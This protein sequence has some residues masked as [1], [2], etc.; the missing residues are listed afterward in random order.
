M[1]RRPLP[2]LLVCVLGCCWAASASVYNL[3][4]VTDASPDY[5]DMGSTIRS[6]TGRWETPE[7][8]C[9]AMFYWTH[10]ARRQCSPMVLHGLACSDPIRQFNDYGYTMCSTIAGINCAIWD[11]M[12]LPVKYW[13]ITN[14]TVPEVHYGGRWHMYDD[15]LSAL[16]TLCD[17]RTIAG[18]EDIGVVGACDASHGRSEPGH[19]ARYHCLTA[20]S[21]NGFLTGSDTARD[22][23]QEA[24][25]FRTSGLMY[26]PYFHDWDRGHRYILN[27]REDEVYSRSYAS[28]GSTD[29]YYVPLDGK[30]PDDGCFRIRGNGLRTYSPQ[31]SE[32][33]LAK[34]AVASTGIRA[35]EGGL[36]PERSG[37]PGEVVFRVEGANVIASLTVRAEFARA[38]EGDEDA[39][40]VSTTN[41]LTWEEVWRND[42]LGERAVETTLTEPVSGAY[43]VLVRV[44]LLGKTAPTDAR[45]RGIS[46]ETITMLNAKTQPQLLLGRNEVY[47]SAGPQTESIVLWPDLRGERYKPFVVEERNVATATEHPGYQGTLFAAKGGEDAYVVFRIDAPGDLTEVHIGG[48]LYNRAPGSHID[49]LHSFDGGRT[50]TEDYSLR[51]TS[52]PW[53]VIYTATVPAPEGVRSVLVKYVLSS[54]EAGPASCSLYAVRMEADYQPADA[55]FAPLEV[56]FRWSERQEDYSLKQRSH[57]HVVTKLPTRYAIDVGGADHPIVESLRIGPAGSDP[58]VR[59]GYSDGQDIGGDKWVYR[60]ETP[61]RDL[62]EGRPYAL[63]VPSND[64]WGA[65]DPE[66]RKLTDGIVGP[67]S[68][69]GVTP[70]YGTG[71]DEGQQPDITVDLGET[72]SCGAFRIHLGGGWPWWDAL[73]GE[74]EDSVEVLTSVDGQDYVSRGFV[75]TKL[76]RKDLPINYMLAD[77]ETLGAYL[78]S[79]VLPEPVTARYVR[80]RIT[81]Q[82]SLCVSEVQVLD[83]LRSEPFDIRIALPDDE[84][85]GGGEAPKVL[86][87]LGRPVPAELAARNQV[88]PVGEPVL[89][90]STLH[91]LGAYWIM[92]GDDDRNARVELSYRVAGNGE[93]KE[94]L[95]LFRVERGARRTEQ[96]ESTLD[97]PDDGWLFAGSALLL[98]P[99]T[100]YELRL[101]LTDPD[102]GEAERVLATRTAREPTAPPGLRVRHVVPGTGGGAGTEADPFRG[103]PEAESTARPGDLFL[104]HAGTYPGTFEVT[105]SG[106]PDAPIVWRGEDG[107]VLDGEGGGADRPERAVSAGGLHDVWFEGLAI[108]SAH[109]GI[110][111]HNSARIVIRG[112]HIEGVEYGITCTNNS[113]DVV[114]GFFISDNVIEGPSTW[115]RSKGIEDA[116]GIQITGT[117]HDV[118]YNLIHGFAD[119]IDTFPSVRCSGLDFHHNDVTLMTDDGMEMDYSERNTRCFENRFTNV[120][121]GISFQPVY[122]GPVY[123]FRNVLYNVVQEPFKLHNSPSGAWM[124]HNTCV[125]RG[126]PL[127]LWT[128]EPVRNSVSR[129]NLFVGSGG[130]YAYETTAPMEECDFDYDGFA[131]GPWGLFLKWKDV[132][133]ASIEE[134]RAKAPAYAHAVEVDAATAFASGARP[135]EDE[136]LF[137]EVPPDLRLAPGS[138]AIDAGE[139]LPG[140]N[141]GFAGAAPDLGAYEL[142]AELPHY[143]PRG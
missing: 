22:L 107:A 19:I 60:W 7:E 47:V 73:K 83:F 58:A 116:R 96:G 121:Q 142:G 67:M 95:P 48:R 137:V 3:K 72:Q 129:N 105:H 13:D 46:F 2:L 69:G 10:I 35:S 82:R 42:Q 14:H 39:I 102:G 24:N 23:A 132:R 104:I 17:G 134:A 52:M 44:T 141:D 133:Y 34:D 93:W 87:P 128:S 77:D 117:G 26:R 66:G 114:Q 18:V 101:R 68:A 84:A 71:W 8:K 115:P 27:L 43:E 138:G 136:A 123:A 113:E 55:T 130:N 25:C 112:C 40:A 89:E 125:K 139:P 111:A 135:P 5:T 75:E 37:E 124:A 45:L 59:P 76:R 78:F 97:V 122:G 33:E 1:R 36:V 119:A 106:A 9:W 11:A 64:R 70:T 56:T 28:L 74:V 12:G 109:Y 94:G 53:D 80:F 30:D 49:Y 100:A 61:G 126:V 85:P 20:T 92:R 32:E 143:G 99:D 98:T 108:R 16:Y 41:G 29:R 131:G 127:V 38:A 91:S 15:S 57:T 81:P 31:L 65:G 79:L 86:S 110:V 118:C 90:P 140:L 6:A 4:V 88:E 54:S 21:A 50:W 51:D 120:F 103:L 62:A 63:S